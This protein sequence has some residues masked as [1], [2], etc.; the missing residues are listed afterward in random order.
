MLRADSLRPMSGLLSAGS[1]TIA[2]S[3]FSLSVFASVDIAAFFRTLTVI[4]AWLSVAIALTKLLA[5]LLPRRRPAPDIGDDDLPTYTVIIPL[6]HE[7]HMVPGLIDAMSQFDYP[8]DKLDIIFACEA[9]DPVTVEAAQSLA[10]PPFRVLVVPP[11]IQGGEPQTKPRALNYCLERSSGDLVTIY[12]A[13]DRPDP[14]QLRR[15]ASAFMRHK[16]WTALQAPLD[17][18]NASDSWL[19][20]QFAI[21]YASLFHVL[22]PAFDRLGLPFPLGGTSN[23]IRRAHIEAA[24]GWD[25][26]N[27][28]EDADLAFRLTDR[29]TRI[30]WIDPPTAEEA[31]N[32]IKPWLRQRS[33]WL[34]GYIQ[35]WRVHMRS[36]LQGGWRRAL[37]LQ[38]TLGASLLAI[39][40]YAPL[41]LILLLHS[42]TRMLGWHDLDLPY[43]YIGTLAFSCICGVILGAAGAIRAHKL[44]LL[45]HVPFMPVY[46]LLLF[47]P[48]I[49]ALIEL[50]TNPF[51]WH[52]TEHGVTG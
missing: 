39:F 24:G 45:W 38:F 14:R 43:L 52:K 48:L 47:P 13:E 30:G 5:I 6:F 49:Q 11:V 40:F 34:K 37:M 18:F 8:N 50:R 35:T 9:V 31:V 19:S 51:Y 27:V 4:F 23:H 22:L 15:A 28:T 10:R 17:Y 12:D 1:A 36:P 44:R 42:L 46:W 41:V 7:A 26:F 33:R 20:A 29:R 3:A 21:E 16:S 32:R 25:P 2:V